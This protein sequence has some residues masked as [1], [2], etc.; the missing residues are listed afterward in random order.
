MNYN[1]LWIKSILNAI[2]QKKAKISE[3]SI[4]PEY[5]SSHKD[6]SRCRHRS[7]EAAFAGTI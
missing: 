3:L 2:A 6:F 1:D 4:V 5:S 7:V